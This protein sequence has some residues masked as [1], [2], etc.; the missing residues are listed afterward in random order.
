MSVKVTVWPTTAAAPPEATLPET[1]WDVVLP[2]A[3][4]LLIAKLG[5]ISSSVST[6][7]SLLPVSPLLVVTVATIT[8][9]PS[10]GSSTVVINV[11]SAWSVAVP[12]V[13][14]LSVTVTVWPA[15]IAEP[16]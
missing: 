16:Q 12:R 1:V 15:T 3:G 14:P 10:F 8:L 11:P 13:V 2:G 4:A 9:S 5:A 6:I 7:A